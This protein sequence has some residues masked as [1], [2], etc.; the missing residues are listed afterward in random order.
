[1]SKFNPAKAESNE[2]QSP[3]NKFVKRGNVLSLNQFEI[4]LAFG[5]AL[6]G[7]T[8]GI[9]LK[10]EGWKDEGDVGKS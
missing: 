6:A 1:M 8:F 3:N 4:D 9:G 5:P 7:L 10:K 2:I